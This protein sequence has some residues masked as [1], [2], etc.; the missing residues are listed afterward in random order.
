M[1]TFMSRRGAQKAQA[2]AH[3]QPGSEYS[4]G[5]LK[6]AVIMLDKGKVVGLC[7]YIR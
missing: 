6:G 7:V 5:I 4:E 1:G 2:D 3:H